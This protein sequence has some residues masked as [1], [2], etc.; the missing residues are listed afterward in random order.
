MNKTPIAVLLA[1]AVAACTTPGASTAD[2]GLESVNQPVLNRSNFAVDVAAPGGSLPP[3]E[4]ARLD[5]WFQSLGLGYGDSIFV[6]GTN[7]Q[8]AREQ[9]AN[10]AG[11]YGMMIL[12]AAPV[13]AGVIPPGMVR[14]IVTR[15]RAEVPGC[16]NW[17]VASQPNFDNRSM[18][19]FGCGLNS[20]LAMQVANPEDLF[21]GRQ[22]GSTV[23]TIAG[24]KAIMMYR[25]WQLT[26]MQSGQS[27]RALTTVKSSTEEGK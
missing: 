12:P 25:N 3:A 6:D 27:Q 26:G 10:L 24:A 2:R 5:G 7:A 18:S 15:T 22:S 21:H 19:N 8:T 1:S 9:V 14:V 13:T 17:S 16:P 20:D 4:I 11:K 23:D